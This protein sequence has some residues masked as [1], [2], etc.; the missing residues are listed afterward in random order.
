MKEVDDERIRFYLRR[1]APIDQW[2]RIKVEIPAVCGKFFW[3][4]Q[5]DMEESFLL[6]ETVQ[7]YRED[8]GNTSKLFIY[9][10]NWLPLE[11]SNSG[12]HPTRWSVLEL[13][14][15]ERRRILEAEL[16]TWVSGTINGLR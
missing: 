14:G 15:N 6:D 2:A 11:R 7:L 13:S 10:K 12:V 3:S 1:R 8:E 4:L 9:R 16:L 5:D